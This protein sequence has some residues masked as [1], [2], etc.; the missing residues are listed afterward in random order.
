MAGLKAGLLAWSGTVRPKTTESAGRALSR[1]LFAPGKGC[2]PGPAQP[3]RTGHRP[4]PAS[5]RGRYFGQLAV[6]CLGGPAD[7]A[8][9]AH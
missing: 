2:R 8:L 4:G 9:I 3:G 1:R 5:G 6:H 7:C